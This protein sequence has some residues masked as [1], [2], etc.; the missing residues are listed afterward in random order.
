MFFTVKV[1][2]NGSPIMNDP[3]GDSRMTRNLRASSRD[4]M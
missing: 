1:S 2:S 3:C 4:Q